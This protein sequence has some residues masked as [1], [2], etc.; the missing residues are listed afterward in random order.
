MDYLV[1][2]TSIEKN[3][4]EAIK[5]LRDS[6]IKIVIITNGIHWTQTERLK[7][8]GLDNIIDAF[9]TSTFSFNVMF[10][11]IRCITDYKKNFQIL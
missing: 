11:L 4:L 9:F 5:K 10:F 3:I 8:T 2:T 6:G 7:N 1:Q